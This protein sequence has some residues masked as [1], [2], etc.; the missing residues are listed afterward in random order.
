MTLYG[1]RAVVELLI[2][3]L[4][5]SELS[6][7]LQHRS[8]TGVPPD[9]YEEKGTCPFEGCVYREWTAKQDISLFDRPNGEQIGPPLNQGTEP[10]ADPDSCS[11]D[12]AD[13]P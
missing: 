1:I 12:F 5:S 6:V 4:S 9:L 11:L 3:L 13:R 7:A 8:E 2:F 10:Y